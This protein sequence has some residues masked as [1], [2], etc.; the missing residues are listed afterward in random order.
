MNNG[1]SAQKSNKNLLNLAGMTKIAIP[2][3]NL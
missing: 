1:V 3:L 2:K